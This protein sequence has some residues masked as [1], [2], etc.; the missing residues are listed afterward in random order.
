MSYPQTLV[1]EHSGCPYPCI[2]PNRPASCTRDIE[3]TGLIGRSNAY[4][5]PIADMARLKTHQQ[6]QHIIDGDILD[7]NTISLS[8]AATMHD[9]DPSGRSPIR[10]SLESSVPPRIKP[11][12]C[13]DGSPLSRRHNGPD[14]GSL[15]RNFC[16]WRSL[17]SIDPRFSILDSPS[18]SAT[19]LPSCPIPLSLSLPLFS[20]SLSL[21][22][23]PLPLPLAVITS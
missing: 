3:Q 20:F 7:Q 8:L 22:S 1:Q 12:Y 17:L 23:I 11:R 4:R 9:Y 13:I 18:A 21:L 16:L 19:G 5:P 6:R 15:H 10:D 14:P 2:V